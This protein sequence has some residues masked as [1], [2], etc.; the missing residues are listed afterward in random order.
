MHES[1]GEVILILIMSTSL[2]LLLATVVVVAL[3]IQNKRKYRHK[4][5]LADMQAQ[6]EKTLLQTQL[7]ILD[8]TY[9]A[10]SQNLHDNIGS[11]ISTAMLLLYKDEKMDAAELESN[12]KEALI[13]LD[14]VVDDLRNIAHSL[15]PGY[16]DEIGLTE[17]I[18]QR[19]DQLVKTKKYEIELS[20][21]PAKQRLNR[22]KQ[23]ILFYIFQEAINNIN[24]HSKA[25]KIFVRIRYED[26][27]VVLQVKDD[28]KGINPPG[29]PEH[30]KLKGSGL[31]N[32]KNN[33]ALIGAALQIESEQGQGT[34]VTVSVP[35]PYQ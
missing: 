30:Q 6:Y 27:H 9:S 8:E 2:I 22:Q 4:V 35:D 33:A 25:R 28:G 11:N 24:L 1:K 15:N 31:L 21:T 26:D 16:L 14:K 7:K 17:A 5:Q 32:M 18:K 20:H 10:I 34:D 3:L 13:I 29:D 19:V 23:V 12:R